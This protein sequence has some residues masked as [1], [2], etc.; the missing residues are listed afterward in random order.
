MTMENY[1]K[2]Y[3][4][5]CLVM[6]TLLGR[7][8]LLAQGTNQEFG[9]NRVQ[10]KHFEWSYFDSDNFTTFFYLGGQ[11]IGKYTIIYAEGVLEEVQQIL[12]FRLDNKIDILVYNDLSDLNQTN[13]GQ[14]L[15]LNN[16]GGLTKI[17]DN[18]IF[19]YFDGNHA[20]LE[21]QIRRG[22]AQVFI[23]HMLFGTSF[24]EVLQN[25]VL[26]NLPEWF[27][28]GLASYIGQP[29]SSEMDDRLRDGILSGRY[30]KIS[31]LKGEEA[32]FVGHA[33]W[34]YVEMKYGK[35]AVPNLLYLTRINRSME[36]GFLF[37]L[38]GSTETIMTQWYNDMYSQ[39]TAFKQ[40]SEQPVSEPLDKKKWKKRTHYQPRMSDDGKHVAFVTNILGQYRVHVMEV[41]DDGNNKT[42]RVLKGGHKTITL[43][44]DHSYPLLAWSPDNQ[45]LAIIYN[46]RDK[47]KMILYDTETGKKDHRPVTKFQQVHDFSFTSNP[48]QLVLSAVNMGHTDIYLYDLPSTTMQVLTNDFYDDLYPAYIKMQGREGII[49][50]S[51]RVSDTLKPERLDTT[52][53]GDQ[54]DLFFYDLNEPSGLLSKLTFTA[55][56]NELRPMQYNDSLFAFTSDRNGI[57]NR[58]VGYFK[59]IE[60]GKDTVVFF[61]D[62][63]VTN[64]TWD[65]NERLAQDDNLIDSFRIN[66]IYKHI[67]V[68]YPNSNYSASIMEHDISAKRQITLEMFRQDNLYKFYIN[69]LPTD[70]SKQ[71]APKLV[72]T[73]YRNY[74]LQ[75]IEKQKKKEAASKKTKEVIVE[76]EMEDVVVEQDTVLPQD[77]LTSDYYFQNDWNTSPNLVVKPKKSGGSGGLAGGSGGAPGSGPG[78]TPEDNSVF[79]STRV[80]PYRLQFSTDYIVTQIDNSLIMTRYEV[81]RPGV[82][83]FNNPA[84]S[85]MITLGIADLFED[86]RITGG[87]RFPFNFQGSEYFLSYENLRKRWDKRLTYYR[88]VDRQSFSPDETLPFVGVTAPASYPAN[89]AVEAKIKTNY[90]EARFKFPID[91]IKSLR[92]YLAYRND[93]Y[94]YQSMERFTLELPNFNENW[95]FAKVEYVHDKTIKTGTNLYNGFRFKIWGEI[96]KQF[97][98][99]DRTILNNIDL[100]LPSF[101]N[102]YFTVF[103]VDFRYYQKIHKELTWCN[104]L[105]MGTS[106]GTRKLMY[107]LGGVESW[108][109]PRFNNDIP[110]SQNNDYAFQTVVN[111]MR[112][113]DQNIRNGHSYA[114]LNSEIRWPVFSYFLNRT[115]RS[116]FIKNFQVIGFTDVGTA[117][118]GKDPY[119]EEN[120]LFIDEIDRDPVVIRVEYFRNPIVV[121]YGF[122]ARSTLFGYYLRFDVAWGKDTGTTTGPKFYFSLAMDF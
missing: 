9:Q 61:E 42:K 71:A 115:I 65:L 19:I 46:Q 1:R 97:N 47:L 59:T 22:I 91:V 89:L 68:T 117:W 106:F 83:V 75:Q 18:K 14:G 66:P 10:Y 20:N 105:A 92:F 79:K 78:Q 15:D 55:N 44:T 17:I 95:L 96:H 118:E 3:I 88:R 57:Y 108:I 101:D 64:P 76:P 90:V 112:G 50:S 60:V 29:W 2:I 35:S 13:I 36:S 111:N 52:L 24:Q 58:Y 98:M 41:G 100:K 121:G 81:F 16:T 12:E 21:E 45:T 51:N 109:A 114:V 116:E 5:A 74:E 72:N 113:F 32:R 122:G 31:K 6:L 110:V 120:P 84:L 49:F 11:D 40:V 67:G 93:T 103:G 38:G 107:Y 104:R 87:M 86:I 7:A 25:A 77:P 8:P 28:N 102:R 33:F 54:F 73:E 39:F 94:V 37:V 69:S 56:A 119:D 62:S 70:P 43:V 53:L 27:S 80:L 30:K 82:P 23:N 63:T 85:G 34:H 4:S 48:N 99:E 26:L